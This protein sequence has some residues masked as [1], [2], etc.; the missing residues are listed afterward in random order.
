MA[1]SLKLEG[2]ERLNAR[3]DADK[4]IVRPMRK[5]LGEIGKVGKTESK[6]GAPRRQGTLSQS[7]GYRVDSKARYVAFQVSAKRGGVS[8]PRVLEF[9]DKW[10]H[11]GWLMSA[12][13]GVKRWASGALQGAARD[14]EATFRAGR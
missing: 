3:L 6:A 1:Y 7:I 4:L 10:G 5:A 2:V 14:M 12:M 9:A 13:K 8:Y 11:A